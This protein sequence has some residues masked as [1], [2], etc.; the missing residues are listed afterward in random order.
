MKSLHNAV[1]LYLGSE[2]RNAEEIA[3]LLDWC[4][5]GS[6]GKIIV[7]LSLDGRHAET[8]P[9]RVALLAEAAASRNIEV[10]GMVSTLHQRV[11]SRDQLLLND[12]ACYCVDAHGISTYDEPICGHGYVL[13]PGHP[14]VKATIPAKCAE[15]LRQFPGLSGIHLDF[16]RYYHYDSRLEIDT[17]SAGHW[18]GL[19]KAG[20]PIR[21]ETADGVRTTYFIDEARNAY[22]DPPIG[23]KL[24]L[25]RSYR[26]CFCDDCLNG[27]ERHSGIAIPRTP[28]DTASISRW[29]LDRHPAEWAE[30]RA[31]LITSLVG[32]IRQA[33][34]DVRADAKLSAAVWYNA[35]YG[36]ELRGEPFLPESEYECF[37]QKWWEWAERGYVDFVCPM[38]YWMKPGS[39]AGIVEGQIRKAA[40]RVPVYAGLLKTAEYDIGQE[41]FEEYVRRAGDSGAD[42]ICL[43]HYGSW[44]QLL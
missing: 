36:N 30:Y 8:V 6:V 34:R 44:K 42:G 31:S 16:I 33:L 9:E 17:K 22:N 1:W 40:G 39:F 15:L 7:Y 14:D 10:H 24:V 12:K 38:D 5:R 37:G 27:F 25:S 20:Q 4:E 13:D 11:G 43:F 29:L 21:L 32:S 19:P 41:Q 23:D 28:G 26:Y 3:A 18:I 2:A 35:P